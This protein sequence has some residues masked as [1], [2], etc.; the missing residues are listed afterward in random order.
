MHGG[1][2]G[3]LDVRPARMH[4]VDAALARRVSAPAYDS[5]SDVER[6]ARAADDPLS[7]L[8]VLHAPLGRR[9]QQALRRN[10]ATLRD[11]LRAGVFRPGRRPRFA[12][13]RVSSAGHTQTG[14]VAAL[15][16]D[17]Y[18]AGR[19][20]P[21]E[22]TRVDRVER[23]AEYLRIVEADSSPVSVAHR[24]RPDLRHLAHRCTDRAADVSFT[25]DDGVTHA[26]W[27]TE[28][29]SHIEQIRGALAGLQRVYVTDGHHRFA[30]AARVAAEARRRGSPGSD[31]DQWLL[32]CLFPHD[33]LR[34]LP[35]HRIVRLPRGT[36]TRRL[37][38][39]LRAHASLRPLDGPAMPGGPHRFVVCLGHRWYEAAVSHDAVGAGPLGSLDVVTLQRRLLGPVFGVAEPRSDPRIGY[40]AGDVTALAA[41]CTDERA[42]GIAVRPTSIDE[43]MAV[44]D[45]GQFMPPKSTRFDPKV[46]SGI[47][48]RLLGDAPGD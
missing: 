40:I 2:D 18:D 20:A 32:A 30:A 47:F 46:R 44:A 22:H 33:E 5:L 12:W 48:V 35:F 39:A 36:S 43:L 29:P 13:Y 7:Y 15:S 31:P 24:T 1:S 25:A 23:L 41:A 45:A 37:L 42:V 17:D 11:M 8:N 9:R 19:I 28:E 21:H 4:V 34:I 26:V 10:R 38:E 16:L 14:L 27:V 3:G 6:A